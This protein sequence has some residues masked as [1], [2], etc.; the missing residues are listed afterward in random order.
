MG[1]RI[2]GMQWR[3]ALVDLYLILEQPLTPSLQRP[4]PSQLK[5]V[6]IYVNHQRTFFAWAGGR[7]P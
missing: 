2:L 4:S 5:L 6:K 1:A 7:F 3:S